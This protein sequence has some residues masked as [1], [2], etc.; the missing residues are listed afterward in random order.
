METFSAFLSFV[1]GIHRSSVNS[2]HKGQWRGA[3]M[4]SLICARINGWVNNGEAGDL[5]RHRPHYDFTVICH[6]NSTR[7][8]EDLIPIASF[9][10]V[11][12][13]QRCHLTST[14][15]P[16]VEIRRSYDRLISTMGFSIR[17]RW[18]V[19]IESGPSFRFR[20]RRFFSKLSSRRV[21]LWC[22]R[23][24]SQ[25]SVHRANAFTIPHH[26]QNK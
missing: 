10:G 13:V 20:Y 12:S 3:L 6:G 15:N 7:G 26:P 21:E 24:D 17:V 9:Q 22:V 14:G 16:I 4:F 2:P 11:G 5:R 19:Y 23:Q 8:T 18:Y 1:P 25:S